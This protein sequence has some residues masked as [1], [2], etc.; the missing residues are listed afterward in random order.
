MAAVLVGGPGAV[1]S[2]ASA[3]AL[4]QIGREDRREIHVSTA[5][6]MRRRQPGLVIH[7]RR[8]IEATRYHDIPVT[9][10]IVTLIDI[11]TTVSH[12]DLEATINEADK[13][14]LTSPELLRSALDDVFHRPGAARLR[15]TLDHRTFRLTDSALERRFLPLA[16]QAG[17]PPPQTDGL[18]YHRSPLSRPGTAHATRPTR[19]QAS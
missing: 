9:T 17:L 2:H 13:R 5:S 15:N 10:P 6:T 19:P 18:R 4:W 12:D 16:R 3:A 1:L 7:R 11:D 8:A 14:D